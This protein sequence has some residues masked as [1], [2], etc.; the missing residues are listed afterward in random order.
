MVFKNSYCVKRK[1]EIAKLK[2]LY[3]L[4]FSSVSSSSQNRERI[5]SHSKILILKFIYIFNIIKKRKYPRYVNIHSI[6]ER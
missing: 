5:V 1:L 3:N 6:D 2:L 4:L